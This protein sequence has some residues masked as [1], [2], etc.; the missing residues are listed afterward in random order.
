MSA[1]FTHGYALLMAVDE[2]GDEPLAMH[3]LGNEYSPYKHNR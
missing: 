1:E 3:S 2:G